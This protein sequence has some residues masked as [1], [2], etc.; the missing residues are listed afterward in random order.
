[1]DTSK[2]QI[3]DIGYRVLLYL[4]NSDDLNQ[5]VLNHYKNWYKWYKTEQTIKHYLK[6]FYF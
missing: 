1:M 3:S 5:I 4:E 2:P 6:Y